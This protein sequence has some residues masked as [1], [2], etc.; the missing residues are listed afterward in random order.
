LN[1]VKTNAGLGKIIDFEGIL[2]S[3]CFTAVC[4]VNGGAYDIRIVC[5]WYYS[6]DIDCILLHVKFEGRLFIWGLRKKATL[7]QK[8]GFK[9][10]EFLNVKFKSSIWA[11]PSKF[12]FEKPSIAFSQITE[13]T[14]F[15]GGFIEWMR[16]W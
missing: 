4:T 16:L 8:L 9:T 5:S 15:Q 11:A 12:F 7:Y 3:R 13:W 6:I 10:D 2:I 1:D 14:C